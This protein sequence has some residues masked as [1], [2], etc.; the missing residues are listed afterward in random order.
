MFRQVN[1]ALIL[2]KLQEQPFV[3]VQPEGDGQEMEGAAPCQALQGK[4][5]QGAGWA[6]AWVL[7]TGHHPRTGPTSTSWRVLGFGQRWAP[8]LP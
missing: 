3:Q 1:K 7:G 5:M 2:S 6:W 4:E 8:A